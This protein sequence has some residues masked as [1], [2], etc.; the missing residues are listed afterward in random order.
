MRTSR[1]KL[2][3]HLSNA[4]KLIQSQIPDYFQRKEIFE[5]KYI[6]FE[7]DLASMYLEAM[8]MNTFIN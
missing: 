2:E 6:S 5:I 4:K 8:N 7:N 1:E 3:A